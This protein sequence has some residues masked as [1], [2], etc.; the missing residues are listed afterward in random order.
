[1]G[2]FYPVIVSR[3]IEK[4]NVSI[5][6]P[7][8]TEMAG[9]QVALIHMIQSVNTRRPS[10]YSGRNLRDYILFQSL[11]LATTGMEPRKDLS[12]ILH[13]L[14]AKTCQKLRSPAIYFSFHSNYNHYAV[15]KYW[16]KISYI[17]NKFYFF[18]ILNHKVFLLY[19][20]I[21][22]FTYIAIKCF[23]LA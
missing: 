7:G 11:C 17:H 16:F 23:W 18:F 14:V 15:L 5:D 8:G 2:N 20:N 12:L 21:F 1:M 10:L 3:G 19:V 9:E 4:W 22:T 6:Y 13:H